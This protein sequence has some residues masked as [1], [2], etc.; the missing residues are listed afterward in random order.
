MDT[1]SISQTISEVERAK[2]QQTSDIVVGVIVVVVALFLIIVVAAVFASI[3]HQKASK[4]PKCGNW[5]RNKSAMQTVQSGDK[6]T[7]RKIIVCAK[8]KHEYPAV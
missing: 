5:K 4:C 8:C 3:V 7:T 1:Q 6:S 2:A